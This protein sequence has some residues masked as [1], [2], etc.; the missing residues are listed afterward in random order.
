MVLVQRLQ[1]NEKAFRFSRLAAVSQFTVRKCRKQSGGSEEERR[2]I[3]IAHGVGQ[4]AHL[5]YL[6]SVLYV[7]LLQEPVWRTDSL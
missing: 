5:Q 1:L 6:V 7:G 3:E 2:V 4:P